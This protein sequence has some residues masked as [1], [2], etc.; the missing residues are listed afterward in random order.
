MDTS[1]LFVKI[2]FLMDATVGFININQNDTMKQLTVISVIFM[3]INVLAGIGGMSEYSMMTHDVMPWP[4]AYVAFFI[5]MAVVAFVTYH[6]LR[7]FEKCKIKKTL[8][9]KV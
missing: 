2:N 9:A 5:G 7:H 3:P 6:I 4:V 8:E 1:L